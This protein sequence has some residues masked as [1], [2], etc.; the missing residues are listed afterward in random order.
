VNVVFILLTVGS[1][2][3]IIIENP[4]TLLNTMLGGATSAI[5]L[6]LKFLAIYAVWLSVLKIMEKTG[7]D[8][9]FTALF[10]PVID[11]L[12]KGESEE[13]KKFISMNFAANMLGM[14]GAATPLAIDAIGEMAK[15]PA[16]NGKKAT[17]NMILF[18]CLNA[19]S[20]QLL[21]STV[22]SLRAAAGSDNPADIILPTLIISA[23]TT[24][25]VVLFCKVFKRA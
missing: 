9:K 8:K 1:I 11:R 18:V 19:T 3:K 24:A 17:N 7:L 15:N 16:F 25:F 13:A 5:N 23:I 20:L 2:I 4:Q 14:G 6:S 22:M 21:P 12:F 10:R